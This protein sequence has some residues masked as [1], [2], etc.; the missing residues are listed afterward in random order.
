[1][2]LWLWRRLWSSYL[3]PSLGTAM[4][5]GCGHKK[6]KRNPEGSPPKKGG[7]R[8]GGGGGGG[9]QEGRWMKSE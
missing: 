4:C 6:E 8:G 7:G 2:L 9:E 5:G 1:M 3:T